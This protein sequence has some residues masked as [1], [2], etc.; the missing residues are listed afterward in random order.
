MQNNQYLLFNHPT[1]S[2]W[3]EIAKTDDLVIITLHFFHRKSGFLFWHKHDTD[4][5]Y[6]VVSGIATYC[7]G[8]TKY[9]AYT[10]DIISIPAQTYHINPF[11]N[12]ITPLI[13]ELRNPHYQITNFYLLY[14]EMAEKECF[15]FNRNML[16]NNLQLTEMEILLS[17]KTNFKRSGIY[18]LIRS[19]WELIYDYESLNVKYKLN[20]ISSSY[21]Y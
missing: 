5:V 8:D 15:I 12:E 3:C 6:K 19:I 2:E 11:N 21:N 10:G 17:H 13:L 7:I 16:P 18:K 9:K 1:R 4:E 20:F 14:Y